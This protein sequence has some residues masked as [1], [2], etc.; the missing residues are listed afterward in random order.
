MIR[1]RAATQKLTSAMGLLNRL[2]EWYI[3]PRYK[4]I[5]AILSEAIRQENLQ[6]S[7][8]PSQS[9]LSLL[10]VRSKSSNRKYSTSVGLR[11]S[12]K[13]Y[14][15]PRPNDGTYLSRMDEWKRE[16][17]PPPSYKSQK[18][19]FLLQ[20][21]RILNHHNIHVS[22]IRLLAKF[23]TEGPS[24]REIPWNVAERSNH[25]KTLIRQAQEA[26][27]E[28]GCK[29]S[30]FADGGSRHLWLAR[31]IL[32]LM[33]LEAMGIVP[34][35]ESI[36]IALRASVKDGNLE[37]AR[38]LVGRLGHHGHPPLQQDE[39]AE[40]FKYFPSN[41]L[42]TLSTATGEAVSKMYIRTE[43]INF[44]IYLRSKITNP[45]FLGPYILALGRLSCPAE[46]WSVWNSLRGTKL[47]D[48]VIT[49]FVEA[50]VEARDMTSAMEF[51]KVAYSGGYSMNAK[52]GQIIAVAI[53]RGKQ[54]IG[55]E[56]IAEIVGQK[57]EWSKEEVK[58][59]VLRF[60]SRQ[61]ASPYTLS[62]PQVAQIV[63]VSDRLASLKKLNLEGGDI[64]EALNELD[65]VLGLGE[66]VESDV[67][68]IKG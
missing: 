23:A 31:G 27:V 64:E 51:L 59:V 18:T 52:Q 60:L 6:S 29:A 45:S 57:S 25:P 11:H 33:R 12:D 1:L 30:N 17:P 68:N 16:A 53:E 28:A 39:I 7:Q 9:A 35:R 55:F 56:L 5:N 34:S 14:Y 19:K 15:K 44:L 50:F 36:M 63:G 58:S 26:L 8:Q 48:G 47:K 61:R 41:G 3:V 20:I 49:S 54:K 21:S 66:D 65:L 13:L 42:G 10:A 32:L 62:R 38:A 67:S 22:T 43:Q 24:Q 2:Y 4:S 46:I 40:L 37:G